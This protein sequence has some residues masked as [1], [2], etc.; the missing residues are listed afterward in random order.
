VTTLP[1][2]APAQIDCWNRIGI[3]GDRSCPE[4]AQVV[5]CRNC[6]VFAAAGRR[7][8]D[9]PSPEGYLA[10][11]TQRLAAPVEEADRELESLLVFRIADEWLAL[12]VQVLVEVTGPRPVHRIPF[13]GGPLA[14]LVNIR[15][16]LYLCVKLGELLG[17]GRAPP[18]DRAAGNPL[19]ARGQP[20]LLVVEREGERWVL[21]ADE[22]DQVL[23]L[24]RGELGPVPATVGRAVGHLTRGVFHRQ[25]KAVGLLDAA[26]LFS[27]L[28]AKIR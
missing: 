6:P 20:R 16:E 8:L 22:V 19:P 5:R 9:A 26:L 12:P 11:W 18:Q 23:R 21:S 28:R 27:T 3:H 1:V 25:Q 14:G 4:L 15:G 17:I 7:F 10:E 13:R 2:V 24:P